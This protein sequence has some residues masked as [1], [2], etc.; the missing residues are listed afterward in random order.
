MEL[1][2]KEYYNAKAA[3]KLRVIIMRKSRRRNARRDDLYIFFLP[4]VWRLKGFDG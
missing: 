3:M 2:R 4:F 1:K